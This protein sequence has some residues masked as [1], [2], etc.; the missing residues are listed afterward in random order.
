V[1]DKSDRSALSVLVSRAERSLGM[2]DVAD[3]YGWKRR[4]RCA[5]FARWDYG[6]SVPNRMATDRQE[7]YA[8]RLP[9]GRRFFYPT[10]GANIV[11]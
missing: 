11:V 3:A 2:F 1:R 10:S 5:R 7:F 6:Q 8:S 9:L 4:P